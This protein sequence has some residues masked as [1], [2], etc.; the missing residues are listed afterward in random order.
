MKLEIE[1][2]GISIAMGVEYLDYKNDEKCGQFCQIYCQKFHS[3]EI[4]IYANMVSLPLP[5][6]A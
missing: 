2:L 3:I 4:I 6:Q 1:Y 5:G